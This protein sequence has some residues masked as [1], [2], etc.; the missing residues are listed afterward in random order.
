MELKLIFSSSLSYSLW[1]KSIRK[2]KVLTQV[3]TVEMFF[4][5]ISPPPLLLSPAFSSYVSWREHSKSKTDGLVSF[6][7]LA[8]CR[9][10]TCTRGEQDQLGKKNKKASAKVIIIILAQRC[11]EAFLAPRVNATRSLPSFCDPMTF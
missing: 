9:L 3:V 2:V 1:T 10:N 4:F 5:L 11:M 7:F 8:E 6:A